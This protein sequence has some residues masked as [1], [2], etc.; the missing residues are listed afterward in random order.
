MASTATTR[1]R[2]EKQGFG[3]NPDTWGTT[4]N[5]VLD[6]I[7]EAIAGATSVATTGGTTT[8]T[9]EDYI[10]DES[11]K[12]I[13]LVSGTLASNSTIVIP[14][15][16]KIYAVSN[17]T[18]GSFTVTVKTSA[19]T[20]V[21]VPQGT[22]SFVLCD[23]TDCFLVGIA[24]PASSTDNRVPR[25]DGTTGRALQGSGVGIDD[26][27]NVTGVGNI[28]LSGTVDG[29]DV[30]TD[31][32][33]LDGIESGATADQ[34]AA[35]ILAALVTVDGTG[36]GLDADLLDGN[37]ASAFALLNGDGGI[38][39]ST[40]DGINI[41]PGSDVNADLLTV[42]V[43]GAPTFSW[44][45]SADAFKYSKPVVI[46]SDG[47]GDITH[48]IAGA[49]VTSD[50]E[51]HSEGTADLGGITIHRHTD[52]NDFGGHLL[53]LRSDGTHASPTLVDDGDTLGRII[54]LGQDGTDYEL[55]AEIRFVV[56]GVAANNVM[57]GAV[58]IYTNNGGQTLTRRARFRADGSVEIVA[59]PL[60]L[61]NTGLHLL[62]TNAS[63]DLII[64]PGSD[65][66]ADRTLTL[67][68]GDAD[69]TLTLG[70]D[71]SISGTAYVSGGTDVAV[72][73]GGTGASDASGARTNLGLAIGTDVQ[74]FD[75]DT[76]KADTPDTLTAGFA[77]TV[78]ND[79]T[80]S[81][82]TYT[83]DQD[84]GNMKRIVNGG[85]FTLAP[86]TDDCCIIVQITNNASAG[87]ITTSGFTGVFG[88]AF[89]TTDGD[90]FI[91]TIIK[92][93]GF[94]SLTVQDVS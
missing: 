26:S 20:G 53:F 63:H 90:D 36:S 22:Q 47:N 52:T 56:D 82:G 39:L 84:G 10:E 34:S 48:T 78:D 37:E 5:A 24:G 91:C 51:V 94:S 18:S 77:H 4:L 92:I 87:A 23:A 80:Q 11:R 15:L 1:L 38:D 59:G 31:G 61:P 62:D 6:R 66:S 14:A 32:T 57:Y 79:G 49:A 76:L 67:T 27:D 65:L 21:V 46:S 68:T 55:G 85:A 19:G 83:P 64:A 86:P 44:D 25:F 74:A 30:A 69:R 70:A 2:L 13:L 43:T 12:A 29:R 16:T 45:E 50:L 58:D 72:A 88:D 75:A 3:D 40:N 17:A 93:N 35:E 7:D 9:D 54:G 8:L 71:S 41:N 73:D 42:G 33:K 28:A 81:S 60:T 89:T